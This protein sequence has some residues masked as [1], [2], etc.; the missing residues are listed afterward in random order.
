MSSVPDTPLCPAR[1]HFDENELWYMFFA[2][3]ITVLSF[4]SVGLSVGTGGGPQ[5]QKPRDHT[6][7]RGK[8]TPMGKYPET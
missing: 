8:G 7:L 1:A 4:A 3:P 6:A 5:T 2:F